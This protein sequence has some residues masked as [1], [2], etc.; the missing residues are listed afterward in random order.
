M[1]HP[2]RSPYRQGRSCSSPAP[3]MDGARLRISWAFPECPR[4]RP[5]RTP[6]HIGGGRWLT[7]GRRE[8]VRGKEE[9][10]RKEAETSSSFSCSANGGAF[11]PGSFHG[12]SFPSS[13]S[14]ATYMETS[15]SMWDFSSLSS[16]RKPDYSSLQSFRRPLSLFPP[17]GISP[18][19]LPSQNSLLF[20]CH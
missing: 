2:R 17:H 19:P 10:R 15:L 11:L 18:H 14:P 7:G 1:G 3:T 16:P 9:E 20:L 4:C 12:F 6:R 8:R 13:P 5:H